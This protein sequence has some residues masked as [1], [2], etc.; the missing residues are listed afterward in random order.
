MEWTLSQPPLPSSGP[1]P[2]TIINFCV[3]EHSSEGDDDEYRDVYGVD[4][5]LNH[6]NPLGTNRP[7]PS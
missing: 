3:F 4:A 2:N 5:L 1:T 6:L 7:I